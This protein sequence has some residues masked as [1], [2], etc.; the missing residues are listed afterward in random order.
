[1]KNRKIKIIALA[2]L[3]LIPS[4]CLSRNK[5]PH[6]KKLPKKARVITNKPKRKNTI[7]PDI[8]QLFIDDW[9][10][11]IQAIIYIESKC[12]A[13]ARNKDCLGILQLRPIYVRQVNK[14]L[15]YNKFKYDDRLNPTK[16]IE[17]FNIYQ[18]YF[19]K[20]K[21]IKKAILLHNNSLKYY[22]KVIKRFNNTKLFNNNKESLILNN[23]IDTT[24]DYKKDLIYNDDNRGI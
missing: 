16:S 8:K 18:N 10:I 11:L 21:N 22:N 23:N 1:M 12:D 20:K 5:K 9:N 3:M 6:H 24:Y 4:I 17:M 19:N 7:I 2:F 13:K 15:G 14:I